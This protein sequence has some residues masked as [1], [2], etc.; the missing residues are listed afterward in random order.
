MNAPPRKRKAR[1][2][3]GSC[4]ESGQ[5]RRK[6]ITDRPFPVLCE[7]SDGRRTLFQKY[8]TRELA[9]RVVKT[10]ANVGCRAVVGRVEVAQ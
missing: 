3:P 4:V 10:L 9:E 8:E 6:H 5:T 1:G 2:A 7:K